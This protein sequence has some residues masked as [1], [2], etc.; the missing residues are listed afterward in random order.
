MSALGIH[1]H[2]HVYIHT[3]SCPDGYE[4]KECGSPCTMT[5][6]NYQNPPVCIA[7]CRSG[8]FC[9]EGTVELNDTC[10][11]TDQCPVTTRKCS[12]IYIILCRSVSSWNTCILYIHTA[13]CPDGYEYKECGS[14]CTMTCDNYQN[15]PVCTAVCRSGCFCPEGTVELNDTCITTDQCPVTTRKCSKIYSCDNIV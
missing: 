10:I 14:P 11:T 4:Y 5:C 12:K 6:D 7:V 1:V 9:P 3:A 2:V 15:P 8:C 13:S